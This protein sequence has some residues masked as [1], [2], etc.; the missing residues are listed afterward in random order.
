MAKLS[1][2]T[3]SVQCIC[4]QVCF[5]YVEKISICRQDIQS[6]DH[7]WVLYVCGQYLEQ[8]QIQIYMYVGNIW[9]TP[10]LSH[11]H[12]CANT[13]ARRGTRWKGRASSI[14]YLGPDIAHIHIPQWAA[15]TD[16]KIVFRWRFVFCMHICSQKSFL[17]TCRRNLLY[18]CIYTACS[19]HESYY[20]LQW[21][22]LWGGYDL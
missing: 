19:M 6:C 5:L 8:I 2:I 22:M 1:L 10:S 17:C 11:T 12:R 13:R 15:V 7:Y 20:T 21:I 3:K 14:E 9:R 4:K 16:V 18:V